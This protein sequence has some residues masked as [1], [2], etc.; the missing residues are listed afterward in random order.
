MYQF[1]S[2]LALALALGEDIQRR[3]LT[4]NAGML[5][6]PYCVLRTVENAPK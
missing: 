5:D 6:G 3:F 1:Q 4:A 2:G